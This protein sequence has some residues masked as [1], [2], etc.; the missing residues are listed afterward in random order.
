MIYKQTGKLR[1]VRILLRHSKVE[2]T[3]RYLD[4]DVE[5]ALTLAEGTEIR[6]L[7]TPAA[8]LRGLPQALGRI[9]PMAVARP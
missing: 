5:D 1:A 3:V 4:M 6:E 9:T 7:A 8:M 2:S